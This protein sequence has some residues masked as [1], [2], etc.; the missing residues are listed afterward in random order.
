MRPS[1]G[2]GWG[3]GIRLLHWTMAVLILF[4]LGLGVWMV[5]VSDLASRFSLTQLHKSWGTVIFALALVRLGWRAIGPGRPPLP[6]AM[7]PWQRH[8]AGISHAALYL[9]MLVIPLSG[10]IMASASTTQDLL[11]MQNLVFGR[12]PLPDPFIP[13]NPRIEAAA[14]EVHAAAAV[15]LGALL[16]LHVGAALHHQFVSHDGLLTR[17]IRGKRAE[18]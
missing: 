9:L 6:A 12:W 17:M 3:P 16:L 7:P 14:Q 18:L 2:G 8:A 13:G 1:A 10:W 5:R 11:H 4:Q 15:L